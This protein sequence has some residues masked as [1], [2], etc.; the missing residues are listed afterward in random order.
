MSGRPCI[1]MTRCA[2]TARCKGLAGGKA[3]K[4][5]V[6]CVMAVRAVSYM[7][8][9]IK[10]CIR[11][12]GGAVIRAGCRYQAAVIWRCCMDRTPAG[13]VT[14]CTVAAG[15]KVFTYRRACQGT[16]CCM[17]RGT[18]IMGHRI[19]AGQRWWIRVA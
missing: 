4:C 19:R 9:C 11:M 2:V 14:R 3:Y 17:T 13:A 5:T 8:R 6:G 15:G 16:V 1:R 18:C 10:Q 12:T 7:C